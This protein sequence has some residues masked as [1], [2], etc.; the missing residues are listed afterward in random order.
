MVNVRLSKDVKQMSLQ[1]QHENQ[2]NNNGHPYLVKRESNGYSLTQQHH[3]MHS[4][5]MQISPSSSTSSSLSNNANNNNHNS[6]A[7][8]RT[9]IMSRSQDVTVN[10]GT[11]AILSCR[12][13]NYQYSKITWRKSEPE[14]YILRQDEK[15]DISVTPTGEARLIIK[16]TRL[17]DSGV[18]LCCVE[19]GLQAPNSMP[20]HL[21]CSIGLVV[22]PSQN[23][24]SLYEP[25]LS[26]ID[27]KT[28]S[29]AWN[30]ANTPCYVEY[31][32]IGGETM[33][34]RRETANPVMSNYEIRNLRPGES[35]TFRLTNPQTGVVGVASL[36]LTLPANDVELWQLQH[37][38]NI[39]D[40]YFR[41]CCL[42][43]FVFL[44]F[45]HRYTVLSELGRGRY[46]V[47]KLARDTGTGQ[48]VASKQISRNLQALSST[49]AEYKIIS[50]ITHSNVAKG[51][52]LYQNAPHPGTDTIV[53]E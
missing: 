37:V 10:E 22:T 16:H 15:Y 23:P 36:T 30:P 39:R 53:M 46:S 48:L 11:S 34:W 41:D 20:Y 24:T 5:S 14:A 35:Y 9:E 8:L 2:L 6:S 47:V 28:I 27:S 18:Y 19:N 50:A 25:L 32:R 31:C 42:T 4:N 29:V 45:S 17:T 43:N 7:T 33:E 1:Q 26:I 49:Q 21:Q 51:L 44:Q 13:K 3:L 52:C 40:I 12:L 38:R